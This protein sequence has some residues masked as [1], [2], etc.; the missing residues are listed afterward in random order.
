MTAPFTAWSTLAT[1]VDA[2]F[3]TKLMTFTTDGTGNGGAMIYVDPEYN[4]WAAADGKPTTGYDGYARAMSLTSGYTTD[5]ELLYDEYYGL[6]W[7]LPTKVLS[8]LVYHMKPDETLDADGNVTFT[9]PVNSTPTM[10][11]Y[12]GYA[13]DDAVSGYYVGFDIVIGDY[14]SDFS[15]IA[16]PTIEGTENYWKMEGAISITGFN[17]HLY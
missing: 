7:T 11:V 1:D 15:T 2:G 13:P 10:E 12:Y 5:G 14:L 3:N 6:C 8:C 9:D 17:A 4:L 16:A